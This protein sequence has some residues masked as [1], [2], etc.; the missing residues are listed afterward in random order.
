MIKSEAGSD[1]VAV[2][3][4]KNRLGKEIQPFKLLMEDVKD[5]FEVVTATK[6]IYSGNFEEKEFKLDEA[7]ELILGALADGTKTI[8]EFVE[9]GKQE[10][11]GASNIRRAIKSLK[12]HKH[13][14]KN[15]KRSREDLYILPIE[16]N[17]TIDLGGLGTGEV[18]N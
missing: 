8:N 15:G 12:E 13:I 5:E 1:D 11:I 2:Y 16:E 17:Q 4:K 6:L 10:E 14:Q 7:K 3:Q 9:L 18:V